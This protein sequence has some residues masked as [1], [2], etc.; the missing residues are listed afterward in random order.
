MSVADF[1]DGH[2]ISRVLH[3]TTNSGFLGMLAS[4]SVKS[5]ERLPKEKLLE[6]I[7]EYNVTVRKDAAWL[8]YVNL[9]IEMANGRFFTISSQ[10]WHQG[11]DKWWV[12][13]AFD[14]SIL[15]HEGVVFTTTNNIY[16]GVRRGR[17]APGIQE[18]YVDRVELWSGKDLHRT[19]TM[20]SSWTTCPQ[21]EAL[22][23]KELSLEYLQEVFV[24][25]PEHNDVVHAQLTIF[26]YSVPVTIDPGFRSVTR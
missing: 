8:D 20:A 5:R 26:P 18:L 10:H 22:Y 1:V 17:G 15:T 7:L 9:S 21:A 14:P 3:F 23:P 19:G 11:E 25:M 24:S 16:S 4:G 12:V 2:G 13:L 6:H